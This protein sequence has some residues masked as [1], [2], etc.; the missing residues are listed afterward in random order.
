MFLAMAEDIRVV[1]IK[2]ADRL[3]NM[4][5]L[6]ALPPEK[7]KKISRE[8]LEIF[9][10]LANRLGIYNMRR[11]LEDLSLKYLDPIKYAE[12][13]QLLADDRDDRH[14]FIG[15]AH[16][17]LKGKVCARKHSGGNYRSSQAYLFDLQENAE[18]AAR[19]RAHL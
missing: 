4:R 3:H 17:N 11:E 16:H 14:S 5:T 1:L 7:Q 19:F 10:P 18:Q 2:L 13:E 8:T 6:Y 15:Q 12:I 9:A